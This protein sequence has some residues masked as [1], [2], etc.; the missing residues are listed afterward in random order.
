LKQFSQSDLLTIGCGAALVGMCLVGASQSPDLLWA[1]LL[2]GACVV[3]LLLRPYLDRWRLA[4]QPRVAYD[5]DTI[6]TCSREVV[7]A[8]ITWDELD[9]VAV[10]TSDAGPIGDDRV[11]VFTN[12]SRSKILL[13]AGTCP[14]FPTLL[15]ALQRLPDFDNVT[16]LEATGSTTLGRFVVWRRLR[17]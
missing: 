8:S 17:A 14:G 15:E 2:F 16:L 1:A 12:P 7:L 4:R 11:W 13:I 9:E 6:R 10:C 5:A 3:V